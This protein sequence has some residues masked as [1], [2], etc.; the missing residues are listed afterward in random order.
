MMGGHG[1]HT[2]QP[3]TEPALDTLRQRFA[4]GELTQQEC[5]EQRNLLLKV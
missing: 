4:S 3:P 2:D 1:G 5:Q